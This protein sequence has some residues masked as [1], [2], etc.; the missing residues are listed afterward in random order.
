MRRGV[1]VRPIILC[2][3]GDDGDLEPGS[4]VRGRVEPDKL[5]AARAAA[6]AYAASAYRFL[7]DAD[8]ATGGA[9]YDRV[10]Q[11]DMSDSGDN[12]GTGK[13]KG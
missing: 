4:S 6:Y 12:P 1:T 13:A 9:L 5:P 10:R 8:V 2:P 3:A 11:L 7:L